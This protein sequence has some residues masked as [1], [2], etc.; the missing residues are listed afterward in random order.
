MI[1]PF[2]GDSSARGSLNVNPLSGL[3]T[4][5]GNDATVQGQQAAASGGSKHNVENS[6]LSTGSATSNEGGIL[7]CIPLH[8]YPAYNIYCVLKFPW[9]KHVLLLCVCGCFRK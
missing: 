6:S 2:P 3:S 5:S 9:R 1:L 7:T 8:A 4:K